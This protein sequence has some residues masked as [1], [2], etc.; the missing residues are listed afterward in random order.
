VSSETPSSDTPSS[1]NPA[2]GGPSDARSAAD[3]AEPARPLTAPDQVG[4]AFLQ[5]VKASAKQRGARPGAP[6]RRAVSTSGSGAGPSGRDP[7]LLGSTLESLFRA[8]GW[9]EQLSVGSVVGRWREIVGEEVAAHC[10]PEAFEDHVLT[11]QTDSTAWATQLN[12]LSGQILAAISREIGEGAVERLVVRG[13]RGPGFGR[14]RRSVPG[15]GPRDT[16]G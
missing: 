10:R 5:R 7:Q 12:L 2:A 9:Q 6:V 15:R 3:P 4:H 13:P 1:G 14:G 8:Q 16:F 11:V